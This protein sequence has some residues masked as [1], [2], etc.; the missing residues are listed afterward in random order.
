[1]NLNWDDMQ[2]FHA[3]AVAGSMTGAA[4][5]LNLSQPQLS[6]RLRQLED[7]IGARLF[8][9]T[10]QGLKLTRA[11]ETLLP[12]AEEMRIAADAVSRVTPNLSTRGLRKV[13]LS[14]DDMRVQFIN[15]HL[16]ELLEAVGDIE[17]EFHSAHQHLNLVD[18]TSDLQLRTCLPDTDTVIM[19]KLGDLSYAIYG[20]KGWVAT[21]PQRSLEEHLTLT[22]WIGFSTDTKWYPEERLWMQ[23][24]VTAS[25]RLRYNCIAD[26]LAGVKEGVGLAILPRFMGE[27]EPDLINL[28]GTLDDMTRPEH[29]FV[30]RDLLREPAIRKTIDALAKIYR[31]MI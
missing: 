19:R 28:S 12:H 8:D 7:G 9:R 6:R 29:V 25:V 13:R 11:G 24:N 4:R 22:P 17:L 1:M 27:A 2:L 30:N 14:V 3:A 20:N 21:L 31:R 26:C 10:P 5:R 23:D 16:S 15:R 18:R